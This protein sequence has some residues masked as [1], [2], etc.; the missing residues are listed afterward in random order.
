RATA[1]QG[2][3]AKAGE[4]RAAAL[5]LAA[6]FPSD[7]LQV[8]AHV[9][10]LMLAP[11]EGVEDVFRNL[12]SRDAN[13][14][15]AR[16][17]S[18]L[19]PL[20]SRF[21]FS[22]QSREKASMADVVAT[23]GPQQGAIWS[24]AREQLQNQ[25]TR[26][27]SNVVARP[28]AGPPLTPAAMD[29]FRKAAEVTDALFQANGEEPHFAIALRPELSA[30]VPTV[31]V[32]ID[33]VS[34]TFTRTSNSYKTYDWYGSRAQSVQ[35]SVPSAGEAQDLSF[36]GPWALFDL[37]HQADLRDAGTNWRAEFAKPKV[38]LELNLRGVAPIFRRDYFSQWKCPSSMVQ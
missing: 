15:G 10:R 24:F 20:M 14:A 31:R 13:E 7:S 19:K 16:F 36:R 4:A 6:K 2:A 12:G 3:L 22:W 38:A 28:G 18:M 26:L 1:A 29:F 11:V 9:K 30:A 5:Q 25:V 35:V 17:C 23:F 21:P 34:Q 27:G 8:D 32:D 33:G 37:F